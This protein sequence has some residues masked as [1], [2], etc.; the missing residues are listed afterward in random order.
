M[1]VVDG[2]YTLLGTVNSGGGTSIVLSGISTTGY[3]NF[4][5]TFR[6]LGCSQGSSDLGLYFNNTTT[7]YGWTPYYFT[8]VVG[9]TG[10]SGQTS[11][12]GNEI[13]EAGAGGGGEVSNTRIRFGYNATNNKLTGI[14][15][16]G[17]AYDGSN[18]PCGTSVFSAP[19]VSAAVT[20]ITVYS[21]SGRNF[22]TGGVL[23]LWGLV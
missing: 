4:V 1:A 22:V 10:V 8:S 9:S 18:R 12:Q 2:G 19:N 16:K 13:V 20:S 17:K 14:T 23:S 6:N 7:G 3:Q 21:L 11:L 5:L 15:D